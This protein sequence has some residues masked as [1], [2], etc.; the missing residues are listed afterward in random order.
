MCLSICKNSSFNCITLYIS[1]FIYPNLFCRHVTEASRT[2]AITNQWCNNEDFHLNIGINHLGI[3]QCSVGGATGFVPARTKLRTEFSIKFSQ[4]KVRRWFPSGGCCGIRKEKVLLTPQV[5]KFVFCKR[6]LGTSVILRCSA[7]PTC[8]LGSEWVQ[9]V[10]CEARDEAG[11]PRRGLEF[12]GRVGIPGGF[13]VQP[14]QETPQH[15]NLPPFGTSQ[16]FK[17]EQPESKITSSLWA[18]P[19]LLQSPQVRLW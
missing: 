15:L 12:M 2:A 17:C 1:Y 14:G 3:P 4:S 9:R 5:L 19:H 7:V 18:E 6:S 13:C 8:S 10:Q 11:N 16:E